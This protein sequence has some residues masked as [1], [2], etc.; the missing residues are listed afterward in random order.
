M[1]QTRQDPS[2]HKTTTHKPTVG[3]SIII[4]SAAGAAEV[5][6]DHPLWSIKTRIQNSKPFTLRPAVL[7]LGILP[8][9]ASV[10][11]ITAI[12]V[13]LD[14]FFQNWFFDNKKE[15]TSTQ[16]IISAFVAGVGSAFV[17]C[18]TEMVMTHQQEGNQSFYHAGNYLIKQ[19]GMRSL[20]TGL[21]ATAMREG[22]FTAFY[23]AIT[24]IFKA[25]IQQI[26]PNANDY[27]TS[28]TAGASSGIAATLASQAVDTIKTT[29]QASN[30]NKPL[31][32]K[33]A[34]IK[35]YSTQGTYGFF[36]G[37]IPRGAR[38]MSAVTIMG[39]VK[40]KMEPTFRQKQS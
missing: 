33:E 1:T 30:P 27:L 34:V 12:Q 13:G 21:P 26:F 36:K 6:I 15:A 28:L 35:I 14:R 23:L 11:P 24:P 38:V 37:T 31:G 9:A 22:L 19:S 25:N 17:S 40:E 20:F 5:L 32:F 39:W 10:I 3:Q 8:N 16:K 4:G 29:Q 2:T 7:Y 18:P